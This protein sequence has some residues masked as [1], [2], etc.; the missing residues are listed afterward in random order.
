MLGSLPPL[1][2]GA[3]SRRGDGEE[4]PFCLSSLPSFAHRSC[5]PEIEGS[6]CAGSG[7]PE[8]VP[9]GGMN[10]ALVCL[11][12]KSEHLSEAPRAPRRGRGSKPG[13]KASSF[14]CGAL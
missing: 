6:V 1:P 2:V 4:H 9:G 13:R 5:F 11:E 7:Q 8:A 3:G 12:G 14:L 10:C